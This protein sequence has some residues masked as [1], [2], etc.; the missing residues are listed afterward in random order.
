MHGVCRSLF[1]GIA[2]LLVIAG[3][4]STAAADLQLQYTF[5]QGVD[6]PTMPNGI[7]DQSGKG[8]N[9]TLIDPTLAQL[10][11]GPA[12]NM[13]AIHMNK[14]DNPNGGSGIDTGT[15]TMTLGIN[16]GPFTVMAWV[17]VDNLSGD[18]MVFGTPTTP[19]LHLGFRNM[20]I[21]MGFWA[22]DSSAPYQ[23][24]P[25]GEWHHVAWRYDPGTM[26]QDILL[27]GVLL[28]SNGG[29]DPYSQNQE[30]LIGRTVPNNGAFGGAL[31]DVRI[32]STALD[33]G[34]IAAIAASPP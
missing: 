5:V 30:V 33:D 18:N 16:P 10:V 9:G 25:A 28:N 19:A 20:D 7:N 3:V 34:T 26:I 1:G 23:A 32:Y 6:D 4:V 21:Y 24:P 27:D 22:N 17:N 31:S 13:N 12:G 29:H 2:A 8:H 14:D 11:S 15:D